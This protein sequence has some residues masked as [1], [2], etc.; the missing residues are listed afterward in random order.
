MKY[1]VLDFGAVGDGKTNDG[2]AI[3][4][5]IDACCKSGGVVVLP[6]NHT[7]ISGSIVLKSNVELHLEKNAYLKAS[8]RLSDF[9]L[10][11]KQSIRR[12]EKPTW[13]NCDY[14][15]KPTKYFLYAYQA[16]N[17]QITG[18]GVVDGN[19]EIF[20]GTVSPYH[21]DGY[22]YPRVPL[23][24]FED[25]KKIAILN[26]TFQKSAFW[27]THL[28]GCED[29]LIDG[30]KIYNNLRLAN[31]DGIDPDHCKNVLIRNCTIESAD[32]CIV[33]KTTKDNHQY[34]RCSHITVENCRLISTSAAIKFGTESVD[35]FTDITV[36]N[37][38]ILKSNRGISFQLRDEGSMKN[39]RF[40]HLRIETRRFSPVEWWGKGEGISITANPRKKNQPVGTISDVRFFDIQM[41]CE[42][43]IFI[44]GDPTQNIFDVTFENIELRLNRKTKWPLDTHDIR[45]CEGNG[46][47][48]GRMNFIKCVHAK[49][50]TFQNMTYQA[51][52]EMQKEMNEAFCLEHTTGI[53]MIK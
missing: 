3:Q 19:E 9:D 37:C 49:N 4:Q 21:I 29:V 5:A 24:Y 26:V 20:Y 13:E 46:T 45:P 47:I 1:N 8:D 23:V 35:D 40:E 27:T 6:Q 33:F 50:I 10:L 51:D 52:S 42:N 15:G 14:S 43:G 12:V 28:V 53:Q 36:R 7:F 41:D 44:Y 16:E 25:C 2:R 18:E 48:E 17:I 22:F 38:T 34:G 32:D 30:L 11:K 39:I 31:C